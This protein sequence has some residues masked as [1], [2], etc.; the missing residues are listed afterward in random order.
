MLCLGL[1]RLGLSDATVRN[2]IRMTLVCVCVSVGMYARMYN[3]L[4]IMCCKQDIFQALLSG[5]SASFAPIHKSK[6]LSS[7]TV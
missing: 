1:L 2:N 5:L 3:L 6:G 7:N 4:S